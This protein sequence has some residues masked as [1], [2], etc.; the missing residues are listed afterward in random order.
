[1]KTK[2]RRQSSN[3]EDR[4][5]KVPRTNQEAAPV[6]ERQAARPSP[7]VASSMEAAAYQDSRRL[8]MKSRTRLDSVSGTKANF[9]K[10]IGQV[11]KK[12]KKSN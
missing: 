6:L 11:L 5:K 10:R 12:Y 8:R 7:S 2:G 1:M 4:P 9:E 3:I